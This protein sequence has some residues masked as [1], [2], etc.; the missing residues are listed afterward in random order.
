[1]LRNTGMMAVR[2]GYFILRNF[3]VC[4]FSAVDRVGKWWRIPRTANV[5]FVGKPPG[6]GHVED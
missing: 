1:M 6:K 4:R 5:A 2:W 3:D